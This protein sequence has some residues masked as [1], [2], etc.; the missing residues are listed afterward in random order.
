MRL[1][2]RIV[3][4]AGI[5]VGT[6]VLV[7]GTTGCT[8]DQVAR[9]MQWHKEDPVAARQFALD[10][11]SNGDGGGGGGAPAGTSCGQWYDEALAAGFTPS[12][13]M[14]PVNWIMRRES[15]CDP[16]AYNSSGASGLMQVMPMWADD[17][18]GSRSMLFDPQFN[19]R[20]AVHIHDVQGW[21]AWSTYSG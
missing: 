2:Q 14:N 16:S 5:T 9:W 10:L 21:G 11:P 4:L 19:L 20:C 17:C 18:G 13:W 12:E 3:R 8:P 1:V 15:G 6:V 7:G